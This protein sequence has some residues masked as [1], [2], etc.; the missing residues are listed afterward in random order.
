MLYEKAILY[1]QELAMD[2]VGCRA[3]NEVIEKINGDQ[4]SRLVEEIANCA[5]ELSNHQYG[6]YVVQNVL[7]LKNE[8]HAVVV[9]LRGQ[10][11]ELALQQ[12]GSHVV[13]KCME[14]SPLGLVY[15]VREIVETPKA[16]LQLAQDQ[17]GNYVIQKALKKTKVLLPNNNH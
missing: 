4:R 6:N 13:E 8:S 16:S 17:F 10:F 12:G 2:K 1:C 14:A 15:V 9:G 3:L 7:S 5:G 11:V